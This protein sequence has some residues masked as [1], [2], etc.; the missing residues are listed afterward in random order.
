MPTIKR[1]AD[2]LRAVFGADAMNEA[3]RHHGYLAQEGGRTIDTRM[4]R[5][6]RAFSPATPVIKTPHPTKDAQRFAA[7]RT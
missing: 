7:H 4:R 5:D 6:L 2:Q 3:M 1:W